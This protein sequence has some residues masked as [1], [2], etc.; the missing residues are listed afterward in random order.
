MRN[1]INLT[2]ATGITSVATAVS[3]VLMTGDWHL[4]WSA[5]IGIVAGG[6][7]LAVVYW[8]YP[9]FKTPICWWLLHGTRKTLQKAP[10]RGDIAAR[11]VG[12]APS[13]ERAACIFNCFVVADRRID[14]NGVI[15][16]MAD[17]IRKEG[18]TQ[19]VMS[20]LKEKGVKEFPD[21]QLKDKF[22]ARPEAIEGPETI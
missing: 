5:T 13:F 15:A 22:D 21:E 19:E 1:G 4:L 12:Q 11:L 16:T 7:Y 18:L 3:G 14:A 6:S 10:G 20:F 17:R 9:L 2:V 8:I